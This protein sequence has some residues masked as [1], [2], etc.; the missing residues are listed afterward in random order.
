M[1]RALLVR[2]A[3]GTAQTTLG[4]ARKTPIFVCV[5]PGKDE[6]V[7]LKHIEALNS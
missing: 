6:Q 4:I 3:R 7:M 1:F 5:A 2:L